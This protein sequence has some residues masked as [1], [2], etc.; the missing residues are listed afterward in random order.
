MIKSLIA[1]YFKLKNTN[2]WLMVIV[3]AIFVPVFTFFIYFFRTKYFI[4]PAG[5]NIWSN[6]L[7]INISLSAGIFLPFIVVLL[8]ANNLNMENKADSWKR[9]YQ[10][11]VKKETL[12]WSKLLFLVFQLIVVFILLIIVFMFLGLLLGLLKNELPF[13]VHKLDVLNVIT[14]FTGIFMSILG[15]LVLQFI[16]SIYFNNAIIPITIGTFGVIFSLIIATKWKYSYYDPYALTFLYSD[17]S[18][19]KINLPSYLGINVIYI[20]SVLSFIS[21]GFAGMVYFKIRKIK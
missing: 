1:E 4:P 3:S 8:I 21:L 6:F 18:K 7:D 13:L 10:L 11:P 5:E 17:L 15:I 19:G 12:Y 20:V 14:S 9:L 2:T 16:F